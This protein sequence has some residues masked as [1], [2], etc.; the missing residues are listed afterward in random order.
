MR[1][2]LWLFFW[3][4]VAVALALFTGSN[5]ATVALYWP[6]YRMDLSLNLLVLLVLLLV[7]VVHLAWQSVSGLLE[8]PKRAQQ[9]R[10]LQKDRSMQQALQ[11]A[12]SCLLAG[13]YTRATT[14]SRQALVFATE[15]QARR[16]GDTTL[17][18]VRA[19]GH[20]T[21]S[22]SAHHLRDT[23]G[24]ESHMA[25]AIALAQSCSEPELKDGAL[26]QAAAWALQD[27]DASLALEYLGQVTPGAARRTYGLKIRLQADQMAGKVEHA[28]ET[29]RLL[30]KHKAF[31]PDASASLLRGLA[32]QVLHQSHDMAQLSQTW[33]R[34]SSA[35]QAQMALVAVALERVSLLE[36]P[37]ALARSW[38]L[39]AWES[40]VG[41]ALQKVSDQDD[42]SQLILALQPHVSGLEP[43]WLARIEKAQLAHPQN[44]ALTYLAGIACL[45]R[46]LWGK[47]ESLLAQAAPQLK[48]KRLA[49]E[50]WRALAALAEL[51]DQS[52]LAA[53]YFKKAALLD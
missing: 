42:F 44:A 14:A 25:K 5:G 24:R 28:L 50:A 39:P 46:Q 32:Q 34:L 13:R 23:K 4:S 43:H 18:T 52:E 47:A 36:G 27:N 51:R 9:W 21:A 1:Y 26:L 15:L 38:L 53:K 8:L 3:F 37:A 49:R 11:K 22:R 16:P 6:P 35:E 7:V 20:L 45:E 31:T 48:D 2:A 10:M 41:G 19:L 30:T 17:A 12:Q 33:Q 29:A 40:L